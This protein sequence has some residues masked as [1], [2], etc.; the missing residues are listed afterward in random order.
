VRTVKFHRT[1]TFRLALLYAGLFCVSFVALYAVIY[2][3]ANLLAARERQEII[4]TDLQAL[5]DEYGD[6]GLAGLGA[7]IQD[8]TKPDR[9]GEG[10]Y[11]L[12]SPDLQPIVGNLNG[13]PAEAVPGERWIKFTIVRRQL[14]EIEEHVAEAT[15]VQ[16]AGGYNLMVGR[17]TLT[18]ERFKRSVN[19]AFLGS[20]AMMALVA[21]FGG[22]FMSRTILRRIEA[23]NQAAE[24]IQRGEVAHRMPVHGRGDE[25]DR[26]ALNL[27]AML[28]EIERLMGSIRAVTNNIAHDL[29]TPLNRLRLRLESAMAGAAPAEEREDNLERALAEADAIL[30]TFDALLSIAE[31]EAGAGRGSFEPV[32]LRALGLDVAELY[33]PVVEE[34]GL[35]FDQRAAEPATVR[36][37]RQ[38]LFQAVANLIENAIKHGA[39]GGRIGLDIRVDGGVPEITVSDRG[40]GIPESE[41]GRV[42]ERFER[43]D[44]SRS[45]PGSGLGLSLVAAIARLHGAVLTLADNGPGLKATLRFGL[46]A[47]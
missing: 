12:A 16:L 13:W 41:R 28:E 1:T 37:N 21:V 46:A 45:T 24:R 35:V 19:T 20:L 18:Q 4:E 43:L 29:R 25:F 2:V 22:M 34:K 10:I 39:E 36:G 15:H 33:G 42:L 8:R 7:A 32:D 11:L 6:A 44:A 47:A 5:L 40:P 31:A 23:I 14:G 27:N 3:T 30:K 17:D 26:L 38:L 9:V